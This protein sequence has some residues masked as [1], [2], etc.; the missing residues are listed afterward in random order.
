MKRAVQQLL[1]TNTKNY[2]IE[3]KG[4]KLVENKKN[5]IFW[6]SAVLYLNSI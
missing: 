4:G 2:F 1:D 5:R 6:V 3:M